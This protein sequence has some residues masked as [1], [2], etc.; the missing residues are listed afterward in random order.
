MFRSSC[1]TKK[2]SNRI[3]IGIEFEQI[4]ILGT[5]KKDK[6]VQMITTMKDPAEVLWHLESAKFGIMH[7]LEEEE[8]D[9]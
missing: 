3:S 6:M 7:G 2:K 4:I 5:T 8:N 9:E 1:D